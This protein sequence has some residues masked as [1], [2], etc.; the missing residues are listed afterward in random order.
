M[1]NKAG[2][3]TQLDADAR[4]MLPPATG[5]IQLITTSCNS[6]AWLKTSPVFD[7]PRMTAA[8]SK[9]R[10]QSTPVTNAVSDN[11]DYLTARVSLGRTAAQARAGIMA[12]A[13]WV[14]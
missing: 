6:V 1:R 11:S 12:L 13:S 8:I 7:G 5:E 9:R 14:R 3:S 4:L 10:E 2:D